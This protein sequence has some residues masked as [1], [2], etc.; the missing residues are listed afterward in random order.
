MELLVNDLSIKGQFSDIS[1]FHEAIERIISIRKIAKRFGRELHCHRNILNTQVNQRMYMPQALQSFPLDK[2]RAL[3]QWLTSSGPFWEDSRKHS[4]DDYIEYNGDVVT[5]TAVG[6]VAFCCLQ[7]F[8][9][10]LISLIPSTWMFSPVSVN[11]VDSL[12]RQQSI[13]IL[14]HWDPADVENTLY[15]A[16]VIL[17]SWSQMKTTA[18]ERCPN[19]IFSSDTFDDLS[20]HPFVSGAAERI[21]VLL[22]VLEKFKKCFDEKGLRTAEGNRIYQEYFTGEK[23]CFSDSSD[24]EK[25]VFKKR[26]T[27]KHPKLQGEF[28]SCTWHGKVKTPQIRIHFS[29][30]VCANKPLFVVYVGPKLTKT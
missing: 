22:D 1:I 21:V 24:T 8:E 18:I 29:W 30:P 23:A 11:I 9:R 14:N 16:P 15:C 10:H 19:L 6:E 2:R 27:F 20:G 13:E 26:L 4:S 5:D 28:L 12:E 25:N 7:G 3:M 17:S